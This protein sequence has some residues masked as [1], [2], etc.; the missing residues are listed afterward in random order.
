MSFLGRRSDSASIWAY[1]SNY[2]ISLIRDIDTKCY[3]VDL[4]ILCGENA[5]DP[6]E[7]VTIDI[8]KNVI[9]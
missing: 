3:H 2:D 7:K 1:Q 8:E 9:M 4:F 5:T 6:V